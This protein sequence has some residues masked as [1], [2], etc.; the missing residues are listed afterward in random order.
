VRCCAVNTELLA[1]LSNILYDVCGSV[2]RNHSMTH[3]VVII[4]LHTRNPRNS[5]LPRYYKRRLYHILLGL[6]QFDLRVT[7]ILL[8]LLQY[9]GTTLT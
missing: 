7:I 4:A 3:Q 5:R 1:A 6:F 9:I 8:P 2:S